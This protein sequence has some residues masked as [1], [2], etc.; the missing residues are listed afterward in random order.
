MRR[1]SPA[2]WVGAGVLVALAGLAA[3]LLIISISDNIF[4]QFEFFGGTLKATLVTSMIGRAAIVGAG[5][6]ALLTMALRSHGAAVTTAVLAWLGAAVLAASE[7][8]LAVALN[9]IGAMYDDRIEE[10]LTFSGLGGALYAYGLIGLGVVA[11]AL[12]LVRSAS[13]HPTAV[14]P[15]RP[16]AE[17]APT[18]PPLPAPAPAAPSA[19]FFIQVDGVEYGPFD[20]ATIRGFVAEGRVVPATLI[21]PATGRFEPAANIPGLFPTV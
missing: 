15:V 1:L 11:G 12:L 3:A 10:P 2:Q 6:L 5:M 13:P 7:G 18:S 16:V 21:R 14:A 19:S 4:S 17:P 8:C 9:D 20:A